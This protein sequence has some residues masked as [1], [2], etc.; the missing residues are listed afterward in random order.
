[1]D[2]HAIKLERDKSEG[3][4][5]NKDIANIDLKQLKEEQKLNM[6]IFNSELAESDAKP[7][8]MNKYW[9][10]SKRDIFLT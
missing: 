5:E 6:L 4:G 1:M 8:A 2:K 7:L 9:S 3:K 10:D